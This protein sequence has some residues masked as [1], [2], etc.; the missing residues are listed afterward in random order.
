MSGDG[1]AG[2][3]RANLVGGVVAQGKN[4]IHTRSE[5][6]ANSSEPL[7][8][9]PV[10]GHPADSSKRVAF[11]LTRPVGWLPAV[12]ARKFGLPLLFKMA[13]AKMERA[14]FPVQRN[15]TLYIAFT[16]GRFSGSREDQ[17]SR[18]G[19]RKQQR[20]SSREQRRS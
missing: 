10:A 8:R 14:E 9:K 19:N 11:G 6:D 3:N 4:E 7:L 13:S 20:A 5:G 16:L 2:P 1:L 17:R 15:S 12:N 18:A